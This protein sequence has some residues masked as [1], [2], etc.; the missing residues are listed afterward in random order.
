M[1][2]TILVTG[3]AG[4]IG[5]NFVLRWLATEAC[6]VINLDSLSYAGSL[7]NLESLRGDA[8]HSFV[9]GDIKDSDLVRSLL[10]IH[11]P[12]AIVHFAAE[13][14]VDRSIVK[15][16][17]FI[18]TNIT[19]TFQ[20]LE[21]AREHWEQLA[22]IDRDKFV[23]LHVS[24]D[25]V[26]GSLRPNE[27]PFRETA[28]YA[29]NSPYSASKAAADHFVRAYYQTYRLPVLITHSSNNYGP[30]QFPEKLI[31]LMILNGSRG[32]RLPVY[33]DG[34]QVRDWIYVADHCDALRMVLAHGR[35]G[36]T[37]NVGGCNQKT[38]LEVVRT[39]CSILDERQP[40]SDGSPHS[41]LI[42]H[43][44]DRPGHD[45]RYAL[46]TKKIRAE[47]RWKPTERF[48]TGIRKTVDWYLENMPWV[49]EVTSGQYREWM[50][51]QYAS[52]S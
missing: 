14:H 19:G 31:P 35:A 4:F 38:N 13:T 39:I 27:E 33:G 22:G 50:E 1:N 42:A 29:P 9:H 20:L 16:E 15:P 43:V 48:E 12:R 41:S 10:R 5:A 18:Q 6:G 44:K 25:E 36:Q 32:L 23:F 47:I 45:R 52:A 3:G 8:R 24:S 17:E 21:A 26:Y 2:E 40:R 11:R 28:P 30:F 46:D 49:N 34:R 51:L 37:Y 7:L